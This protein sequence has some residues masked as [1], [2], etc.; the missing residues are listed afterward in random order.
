MAV[1]PCGDNGVVF[2]PEVVA[3]DH[4]AKVISGNTASW[5]AMNFAIA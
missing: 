3:Q 4:N 1:E 5:R 2:F